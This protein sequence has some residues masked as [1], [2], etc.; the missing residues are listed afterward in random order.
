MFV[1]VIGDYFL[2]IGGYGFGCDYMV[3]QYFGQGCFVFGFQQC[4]D[5]FGG[6]GGKGF[7]GGGKDGEGVWFL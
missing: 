1:V 4:F 3:G 2:Y 6:Q 7:I 5:C